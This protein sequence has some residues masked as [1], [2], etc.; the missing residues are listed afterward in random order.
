LDTG[1]LYG[2]SDRM[3]ELRKITVNLPADLID[4]VMEDSGKGLTESIREALEAQRN[5]IAWQRLRALR[6][7]IEFGMT[8][9]EAAGKY[10]EDE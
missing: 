8:W 7:K 1:A 10:D 2:I 6:G 3:G 5:A 9:Q 4:G